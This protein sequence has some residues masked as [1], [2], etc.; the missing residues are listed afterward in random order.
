M[1]VVLAV[2]PAIATTASSL[3]RK[4][5]YAEIR[6]NYVAAYC[7]YSRA[8]YLKPRNLSY[9]I[10]AIRMRFEAGA[11]LVERGRELREQGRLEEALAEF[12]KAAATD[13]SSFIALQEAHRTR[14]LIEAASRSAPN[15][16][17][18]QAR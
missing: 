13:P 12:Q 4:G 7:Y 16:T 9:R 15:R 5:K 8:Y 2:L 6:Q 3:Y 1:L 17:A 10:A 11:Q 14:T 18:L